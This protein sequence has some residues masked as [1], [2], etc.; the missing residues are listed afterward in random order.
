DVYLVSQLDEELV[1]DL[2]I[3]P[4]SASQVSRLARRY[5]SCIVLANADYAIACPE[6]ELHDPSTAAQSE[7][8]S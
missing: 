8:N 1:E 6:V 5:E 3:H 2:G 7:T 4:L